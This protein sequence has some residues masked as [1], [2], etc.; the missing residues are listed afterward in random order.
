[1]VWLVTVACVVSYCIVVLTGPRCDPQVEMMP[2]RVTIP[3]AISMLA[4]G[5]VQYYVVRCA[6]AHMAQSR[7]M[8]AR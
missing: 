8:E 5:L 3:M 1:M 4:I 6:R 2:Y 7:R